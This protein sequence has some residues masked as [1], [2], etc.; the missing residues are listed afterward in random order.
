VSKRTRGW[1]SGRVGAPSF[2]GALAASLAIVV[3]VACQDNPPAPG[4]VTRLPEAADVIDQELMIALGQAK[5]FH[6]KAKV[7]VSDG[8]LADATASVRQILSLRFPAGA[9]EADDVRLDARALLAKLLVSQ[10][11]VEEAMRTVSEG[12]AQT[13]R[14]SFFVANLYTVLGEIHEARGAELEA[15]GEKAKAAEEKRAAIAAYDRS[16][17]INEALQKQLMEGR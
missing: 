14:A 2:V 12:L 7:Y 15:A 6:R 4:S 11:Q 9:P 17:Q 3:C 5:N 1:A 13:S 8:N 16:I 10:G